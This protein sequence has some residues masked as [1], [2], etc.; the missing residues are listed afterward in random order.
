MAC[1]GCG[2]A[3]A[4]PPPNI[5]ASPGMNPGTFLAGGGGDGGRRRVGKRPFGATPRVAPG[6]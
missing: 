3:C 6:G 5:P 2:V 1:L 4:A